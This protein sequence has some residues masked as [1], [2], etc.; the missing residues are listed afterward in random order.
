MTLLNERSIMNEINAEKFVKMVLCP[1][2]VLNEIEVNLPD[3]IERVCFVPKERAIEK[4]KA[5]DARKID[6]YLFGNKMKALEIQLK[7]KIFIIHKV[8]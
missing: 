5:M 7:A 6:N 4:A 8:V 1:D 2:P 3:D